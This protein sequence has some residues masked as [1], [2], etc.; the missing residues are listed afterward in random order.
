MDFSR[1]FIALDGNHYETL[2]EAEDSKE[3]LS[4]L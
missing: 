1:L 3:E 4:F 2:A